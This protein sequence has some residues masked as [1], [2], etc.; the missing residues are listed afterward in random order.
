[1]GE[2]FV[3][4]CLDDELVKK[5]EEIGLGGELKEVG[6]EKVVFVPVGRRDLKKLQKK[7][8]NLEFDESN[9]C[10]LPGDAQQTL[11]NMILEL[12]TVDCMKVA[13]TKLYNPLEGKP[14]RS[15]V[16]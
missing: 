15:K 10:Q 7:F 12:Q 4:I 1:M 2:Y 5:I 13:I 11:V 9:A 6:G 3:K 16:F 14:P 8:S